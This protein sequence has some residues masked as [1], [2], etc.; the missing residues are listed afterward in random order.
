MV[1]QKAWKRLRVLLGEHLDCRRGGEPGWVRGEE[2]KKVWNHLT[3]A[4]RRSLVDSDTET[5]EE[6]SWEGQCARG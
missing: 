5:A 6:L 1:F 2:S 3:T 4:S